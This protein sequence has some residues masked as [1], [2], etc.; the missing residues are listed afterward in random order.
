MAIIV[1]L[2]RVT[3]A[4]IQPISEKRIVNCVG[5]MADGANLLLQTIL[6]TCVLFLITIAIVANHG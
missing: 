3:A 1:L 5:N 6:T 4:I 2:Y